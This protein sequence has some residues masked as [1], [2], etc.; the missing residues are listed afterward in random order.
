M[1]KKQTARKSAE[2]RKAEIAQL[3]QQ[4]ADQVHTLRNTSAWK[5]YLD[6]LKK[7]H[8]YSHS[9]LMLIMAQR[10]DASHVTGYRTWQSLGR[11]VRKGEKGIAILAPTSRKVTEQD[12]ETGEETT[13]RI[14]YFLIVRVFDITQ[15][16]SIDEHGDHFTPHHSSHTLDPHG[17]YDRVANYLTAQGVTVE[18]HPIANS[19]MGYTTKTKNGRLKVAID[20]ALSPGNAARTILHEAAHITLGHLD[21][22]AGEYTAHRGRFEVEAEGVAYVLASMAGLDGDEDAISY[23]AGWA[24]HAEADVLETTT[25]NV[26]RGAQHLIT[27]LELDLTDPAQAA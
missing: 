18:R 10:P 16:D 12:T 25:R 11:Q 27:G 14:P 23:I 24:E 3:Q 13:T 6:G 7:F 1:A 17:I 2:Q 20:T 5:T 22:D 15:T 8:R 26:H 4:M 21:S 19:A 9:N